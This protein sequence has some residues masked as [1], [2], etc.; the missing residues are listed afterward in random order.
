MPIPHHDPLVWAMLGFVVL[1]VVLALT[2]LVLG[3]AESVDDGLLPGETAEEQRA[4]EREI[5]DGIMD[6]FGERREVLQSALEAENRTVPMD[7]D[8]VRR[9]FESYDHADEL[10]REGAYEDH[11]DYVRAARQAVRDYLEVFRPR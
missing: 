10:R 7:L 2:T 6:D 1:I 4:R 11:S 9:F 3:F 8:Q 5:T